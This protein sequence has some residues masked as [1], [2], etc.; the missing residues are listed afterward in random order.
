MR[1]TSSSS[2]TRPRTRLS[3]AAEAR[4][5]PKGFSTM[6][7]WRGAAWSGDWHQALPPLTSP[8]APMFS[9]MGW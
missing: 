5:E 9:M 4:S 6:M 2:K 1:K 3:C 7:R 8:E